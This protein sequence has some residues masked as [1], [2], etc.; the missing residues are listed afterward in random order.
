MTRQNTKRQ[1]GRHKI[2]K[3]TLSK[4]MNK[5]SELQRTNNAHGTVSVSCTVNT[6]LMRYDITKHTENTSKNYT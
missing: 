5:I 4:K 6:D 2:L 3:T 1:D